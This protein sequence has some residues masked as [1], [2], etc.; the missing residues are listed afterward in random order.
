MEAGTTSRRLDDDY[1]PLDPEHVAN[2]YAFY[3]RARAEQPVFGS[4]PP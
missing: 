1:A 3:A 4:R 2:P